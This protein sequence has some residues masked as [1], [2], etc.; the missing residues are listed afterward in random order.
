MY[1]KMLAQPADV[2]NSSFAMRM[3]IAGQSPKS[4]RI[5][6]G[7]YVSHLLRCLC[8]HALNWL[9]MRACLHMQDVC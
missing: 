7:A 9:Q 1:R 8:V 6:Y 5:R 3:R 4:C 2:L